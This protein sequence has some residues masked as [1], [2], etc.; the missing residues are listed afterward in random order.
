MRIIDLS[1]PIENDLP[2]DP[3]GLGPH[4]EYRGHQQGAQEMVT[5]FPGLAA[6][7]LPHSEGWAVERLSVT[8]HNGTHVD[9]P[10]HYAST[11]NGGERAWT[12]DEMPLDWFFRPGLK[13]DFRDFADGHVVTAKELEAAIQ[14]TGH[15]LQPLDIVLMN[16]CAGA[17]YGTPQYLASG[18]GFGKEAT[19]WL[20]DRGVR[21]VGTDA[22]SWDAPFAHT[23]KRYEESK[24]A[25]IIW[26]GHKAG[27]L[28]NYCQI[29]KMANLDK[30]PTSGFQV[31]TLPV[32][33]RG[34]SAGWARAVAILPD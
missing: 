14:Q 27:L 26:E 4:I 20:A 24:D 19:L 34:A 2:A 11:M 29:E 33:I 5:M 16:T 10:Y 21:V 1:R 17:T 18:C 12:I 25:S 32:S 30:L 15:L 22:W 31:C 9:A 8:T 28:T 7:D 6:D 23:R 13:L 3:P